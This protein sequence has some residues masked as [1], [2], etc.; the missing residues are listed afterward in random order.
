MTA[1]VLRAMVTGA[2]AGLGAAFASSLAERGVDLVLVARREDRLRSM[3]DELPVDVEVLPADLGDRDQLATVEARLA[4]PT[5]P[6]DLLVNDAGFGAY[7]TVAESD[8]D[9]STTM[10]DVNVGAL[11]RLTHAVLPQLLERQVGGVINVGSTAG[12]QPGPN[13]AVYGAT[14]AY[15]RWFT[16]ALH[17]ELADEDVQALL[18]APG[19]TA[20]EFQ[21]V[22]EVPDG[23]VPGPLMMTPAPVVDAALRAF[24]RGDAVCIPGAANRVA[25]LGA[26]VVPSA[27]TRRI[28][29]LVHRRFTGR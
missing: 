24:A 4:S 14:K 3:A 29:G 28:S 25:A 26:Q 27:V 11:T 16:E 9:R 17:V 2:S 13:G 6:V 15:V 1:P 8:P 18:L 22:A 20:T 10:I 12:F 19:V 5:D 23:A 21:S 7:G